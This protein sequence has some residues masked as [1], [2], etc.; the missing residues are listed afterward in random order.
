MAPFAAMMAVAVA[1]WCVAGYSMIGILSNVRGGRWFRLLFQFGWW[2]PRRA[3]LYIEPAGM[4]HHRRL[5]KAVIWFF[6][7]VF[8]ALAYTFWQISRQG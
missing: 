3:D 5:I 8:F 1:A 2:D 4:P 7:A 6:A